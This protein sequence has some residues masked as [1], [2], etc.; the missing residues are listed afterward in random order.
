MNEKFNL[1][2]V[3]VKNL[4]NSKTFKA[5]LHGFHIVEP[6]PWPFITAFSVAQLIMLCLFYFHYFKITKL[7]TFWVFF[8]FSSV[9]GMWFRDVVIESTYQGMHTLIVQR[10]HKAAFMLVIFSEVMFFFW[11]FLMFFLFCNITFY[12]NRLCVT[13]IWYYTNTS[14]WNTFIKYSCSYI[15]RSY[16]ILCS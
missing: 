2:N 14:I 1:L 3:N 4:K 15:I 12:L 5:E 13:T 16:C 10:M 6:S 9:I 8:Y 11:V 7:W